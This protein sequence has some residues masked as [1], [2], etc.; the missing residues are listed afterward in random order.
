MRL[1]G[2]GLI[3][4]FYTTLVALLGVGLASEVDA[5]CDLAVPFISL[6][7]STQSP[8][9]GV[10]VTF[11]ATVSTNSDTVTFLDNGAVIGSAAL[12]SVV[13]G[14]PPLS[15]LTAVFAAP[16]TAGS[17]T[18]TAEYNHCGFTIVSNAITMFIGRSAAPVPT[19]STWGTAALAILL[20]GLGWVRT[21]GSASV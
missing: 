16:L 20:A 13:S 3:S 18:I 6:T 8:M 5:Q 1:H 2:R 9:V 10:P 15:I 14:N 11:T 12:I 21:R 17:H 4:I 7:S 19:L